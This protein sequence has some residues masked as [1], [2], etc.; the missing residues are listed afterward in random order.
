VGANAGTRATRLTS[1][2]AQP[3]LRRG[4]ALWTKDGQAALAAVPLP[5][6][7]ADRRT[8]LQALYRHLDAQVDRLNERVTQAASGR[9]RATSLMTHPGVGPVTALATEVFLG[10]PSRFADAKALASYVGM[11]PSEYSSGSKQ[12]LGALSKQGNAFLRL[13]WCEATRHAVVRDPALR[14]FYRRKLQQKGF[15][16]AKVAAGRKLGIRLWIML[17][18]QID[19]TEF[20]RRGSARQS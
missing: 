13:L 12:R 6:Y 20:C 2:R 1:D 9:P 8:E 7:A 5:P 19:Y 16:K 18:D 11:M 3:R 14:R 4:P 17:R 15:A 10:D